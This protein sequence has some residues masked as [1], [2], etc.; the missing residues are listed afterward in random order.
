MT[1]Q[2]TSPR[3]QTADQI[4]RDVVGP[5]TDLGNGKVS[6]TPVTD[7]EDLGIELANLGFDFD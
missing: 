4:I 3:A 6:A 1:P 2:P 5:V 7:A